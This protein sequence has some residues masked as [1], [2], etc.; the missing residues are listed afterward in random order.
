M[1]E[2]TIKIMATVVL[3]ISVGAMVF[4]AYCLGKQQ[5]RK[6]AER[7]T[8]QRQFI[9]DMYAMNIRQAVTDVELIAA[10][11]RKEVEY[12]VDCKSKVHQTEYDEYLKKEKENGKHEDCED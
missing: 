3:G 10:R 9:L 12:L 1:D 4:G 11:L 7:S 6:E 8:D 2:I 5:G